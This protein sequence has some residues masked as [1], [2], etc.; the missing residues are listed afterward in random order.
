[1]VEGDQRADERPAVTDDDALV[2]E[3]VGAQPVLEHG[4]GD[5][6]A[7]RGHQDLL[8]A[9][10]DPDEALVV[11]LAD[12]AGVEPAVGVA[13]LGGRLVVLPVAGE[14]LAAAEE[15]LAVV[16]DPDA[17][18]WTGRPTVPTFW[19]SGRF[20]VSAAVVSVSP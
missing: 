8:L 7:A 6:L 19:A 14:D 11:D 9:P 10:G 1:M 18:P 12:V 16:G 20:T 5:V 4:R 15:Q 3:Q 13:G 17:V 2:D